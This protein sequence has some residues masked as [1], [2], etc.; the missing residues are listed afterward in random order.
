MHGGISRF[1]SLHWG[2]AERSPP[3]KGE[4]GVTVAGTATAGEGP[5]K[6]GWRR[7][8]VNQAVPCGARIL[9]RGGISRGTVASCTTFLTP[10]KKAK[11]DRQHE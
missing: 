7:G 9:E 4:D 10:K 2:V 3:E 1:T 8:V 11:A 6:L 5:A